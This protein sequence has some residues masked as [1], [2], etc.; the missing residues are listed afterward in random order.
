MLTV[1]AAAAALLALP[2]IAM[3]ATAYQ[4]APG[5]PMSAPAGDQGSSSMPQNA[6]TASGAGM[7]TN[8]QVL[9]NNQV[10][11][12]QATALKSGDNT[13]VT[14]GPVPDTK[15]NRARYGKP[16]SNAGKRTDPAGN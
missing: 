13:Q 1:A 5:D 10:T 11:S 12:D 3:S 2:A 6:P 4:A 14:N 8:A 16:M 9:D 7:N 15:A